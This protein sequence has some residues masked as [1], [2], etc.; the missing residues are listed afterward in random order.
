MNI[1]N[2]VFIVLVDNLI[3]VQ[4]IYK[5]FVQIYKEFV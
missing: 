2:I 4:Q 3:A 1:Y 5:R